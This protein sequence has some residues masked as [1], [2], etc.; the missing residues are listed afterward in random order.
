VQEL[1]VI[2]DYY[3]F[4]L[5]MTQHTEKFPRHH[6]YS[7]GVAMEN[8]MQ[9]ILGLLIKAKY[10]REKAEYLNEANVELD[11]LRFQIRMA[12]DLQAMSVKSQGHASKLLLGIGSQIGGWLK[13]KGGGE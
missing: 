3:D 5:W 4:A 2:S 6:R 7:L 8:R 1:K 10:R 12:M 11:I 9:T 13:G